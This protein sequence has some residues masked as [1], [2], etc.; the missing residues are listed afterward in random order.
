MNKKAM[1]LAA[2]LLLGLPAANAAALSASDFTDL[3]ELDAATKA[4]YDALIE[5]GI[6]DGMTG[7]MFG[8]NEKMDRAQFAKVAALIMGLEV[9]KDLKTSSFK[10]VAA[11]SS[12][13]YALPTSKRSNKPALRK[14]S[15]TA[16]SIRAER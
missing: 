10:D 15:E 7:G 4:K 6:F 9:D 11:D 13:G 14:E 12:G 8:P 3:K 1:L 2:S 16:I 5:S